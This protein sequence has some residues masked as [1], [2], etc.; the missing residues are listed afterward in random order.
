MKAKELVVHDAMDGREP[1]LRSSWLV[2][3]HGEIVDDEGWRRKR[4]TRSKKGPSGWWRGQA[5][6]YSHGALA[7]LERRGPLA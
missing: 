7:G 1:R 3:R 2:G 4:G 5:A 6:Y